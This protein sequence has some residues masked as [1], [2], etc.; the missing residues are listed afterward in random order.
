M[1]DKLNRLRKE[2]NKI[3]KDVFRLLK[4]RLNIAIDI[5]KIRKPLGMKIKD[6]KREK[7]IIE[8]VIK[9]S[10]IDK[11]FVKR[12]YR[13]LFKETRRIQKKSVK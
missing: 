10:G 13:L 4:K 3:D 7:E 8:K 11:K 1:E 12:Y 5:W 6:P 2:I 9:E